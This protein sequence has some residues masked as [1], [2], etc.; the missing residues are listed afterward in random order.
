MNIED[1]F[2]E[3]ISG[4]FVGE[5][6]NNDGVGVIILTSGDGD[7]EYLLALTDGLKQSVP[8]EIILKLKNVSFD[9]TRCLLDFFVDI[10]LETDSIESF[11]EDHRNL[12][13]YGNVRLIESSYSDAVGEDFDEVMD[14][15]EMNNT[16]SVVLITNMVDETPHFKRKGN[17][18]E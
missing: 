8:F 5:S 18:H 2:S 11:I 4:N 17:I 14:L 10:V 12:E 3:I 16:T 7:D 9:T 15:Q 13:N 1:R 6:N